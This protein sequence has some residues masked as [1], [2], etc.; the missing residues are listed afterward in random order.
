MSTTLQRGGYWD[1]ASGSQAYPSSE[2]ASSPTRSGQHLFGG[3]RMTGAWRRFA[4]AP[5]CSTP[6]GHRKW[7]AG[8]TPLMARDSVYY[9]LGYDAQVDQS[10]VE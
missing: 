10:G 2:T 1:L 4:S 8:C 9:R 3:R 6:E 5:A 7:P